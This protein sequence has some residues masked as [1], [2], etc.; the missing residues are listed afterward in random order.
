MKKLLVAIS[1]LA[2][3]FMSCEKDENPVDELNVVTD[4]LIDN[5][6]DS[7]LHSTKEKS[8]IR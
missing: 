2:V 6:N 3:L 4:E 7:I 5:R 8:N 1:V